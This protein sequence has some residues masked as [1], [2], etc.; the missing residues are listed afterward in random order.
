MPEMFRIH[1]RTF[2]GCAAYHLLCTGVALHVQLH[3]Q[4]LENECNGVYAQP[5]QHSLVSLMRARGAAMP[6]R[7]IAA[8]DV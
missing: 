1:T 6:L 2:F 3:M 8:A 4:P 7:G 5:A